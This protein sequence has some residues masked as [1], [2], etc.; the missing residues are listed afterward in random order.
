MSEHP[1]V[2]VAPERR[3]LELLTRTELDGL[4]ISSPENLRYLS[5]FSDGRDAKLLLLKQSGTLYTDARYT[6]QAQEQSRYPAFIAR[7][8]ATLDQAAPQVAGRRIG[9]EAEHLTVAQLADLKVH[10]DAELV[11][12]SGLIEG[13][14]L[15]KSQAEIEQLRAAQ[16][17]ADA[18]WSAVYHSIVPGVAEREIADALL[19]QI[20]QRGGTAAFDFTVASGPNG[21]KPHAGASE[22]IIGENEL[23][24]VDF[25]AKLGGYHSDMT[26][27]VGAGN[28]GQEL[29]RLYRAVLEAEAAAIAA[30]KPGVRCADLDE[31]A[32]DILTSQ[33]LGEAFAHSL[34]HGV[35]LAIHEGPWLRASSEDVL[36]PGMVVT[37][38]PGMYLPGVGGVRIEDLLLVTPDG[39]EVLSQSPKAEL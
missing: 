23:V 10:W 20:R 28:P 37:I 22:R 38:E 2:A 33:G 7:P 35:G 36:E 29:R 30:V 3:L 27:T 6:V 34:G 1:V 32:R 14:R 5:G 11:E 19:Y 31:L 16:A 24:T 13:L 17:I 9:F 26:R 12:T 15:V 25:G 39:H 8:P 21:A 18:A 4:W